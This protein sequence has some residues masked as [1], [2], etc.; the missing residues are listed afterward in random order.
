MI[1][2]TSPDV[3]FTAFEN[4]MNIFD[5]EMENKIQKQQNPFHDAQLL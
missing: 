3:S 5:A 2:I 1:V 4:I